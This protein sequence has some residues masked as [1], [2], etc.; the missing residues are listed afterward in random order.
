MLKYHGFLLASIISVWAVILAFVLRT[1]LRERKNL[2][3]G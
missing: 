1:W 2:P 3:Q